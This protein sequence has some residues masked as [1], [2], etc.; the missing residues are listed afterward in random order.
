LALLD[1]TE[2]PLDTRQG[3][4]Q[5]VAIAAVSVVAFVVVYAVAV[6]TGSGQRLDVSAVKG[7]RILSR[8]DV[9]V[10]RRLHTSLDIA[11]LTLLG[12]AIVI[13]ALFR[14][15][16]RLAVG[17]GVVVVGSLPTTETLKRILT[18]PNF[19]IG[20]ALGNVPTF[21]SGHTTIA[22][23]LAVSAVFVVPRRWR[24]PVAVLGALFASVIGCSLVATASH[25]PS[26][27]VGAALVVTGWAAAVA[28]LLIG[29]GT[30][31]VRRRPSLL[32]ASPWM[33]IGGLALL[34]ASFAVAAVSIVAFH[35]G[36][37]GTVELGHA[38]VAASAAIV[39]TVFTCM[40][41]LL[42]ALQD[43]ELD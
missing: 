43:R 36:R 41:V 19:G 6:R 9:H 22:M 5:L 37:L 16:V 40:A 30:P 11:S 29:P 25:R 2:V 1:T 35:Y 26:D 20:G 13:V 31:R 8:R 10:A 14:G 18:R 33:A 32:R 28:A 38:F 23:A 15:R 24:T 34:V 7:R 17:V 21:P 12:S 27:V 42:T 39:G 3:R 4:R